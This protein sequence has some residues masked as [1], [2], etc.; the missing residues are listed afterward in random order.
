MKQD[1]KKWLT[2]HKGK[3]L[4]PEMIEM[5]G[6]KHEDEIGD[7]LYNED[8][9]L[10]SSSTGKNIFYGSCEKEDMNW[11]VQDMWKTEKEFKTLKGAVKFANTTPL[12]QNKLW[13]S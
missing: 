11:V 3:S 4:T 6:Q 7:M 2:L 12:K 1:F 8:L 13:R 9:S 10:E 5:I